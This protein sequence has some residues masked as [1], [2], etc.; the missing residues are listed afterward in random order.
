ME[1]KG[2][3]GKWI[4]DKEESFTNEHGIEVFS[5]SNEST[6]VVGIADVY[7]DEANALLISKAPEMLEMLIEVLKNKSDVDYNKIHQLVMEATEIN[8]PIPKPNT[9]IKDFNDLEF[10]SRGCR[11]GQQASLQFENGFGVSVI[12]GF[13]SYSDEDSP[14]EL[15]VLWGNQLCYSTPI[16]NDVMGYLTSEEVTEIMKQIQNLP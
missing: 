15:A 16:T 2:A 12:K 7:L 14:Y 4:I 1:F 11:D 13:G 3:K 8:L 10:E 6:T 5:I 9:Y